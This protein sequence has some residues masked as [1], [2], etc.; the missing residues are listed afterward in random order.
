MNSAVFQTAV[1][2]FSGR[3]KDSDLIPKDQNLLFYCLVR[4]VLTTCLFICWISSKPLYGNIVLSI[5]NILHI[6]VYDQAFSFSCF[7]DLDFI[8]IN[9][10]MHKWSHCKTQPSERKY[11]RYISNYNNFQYFW[12]ERYKSNYN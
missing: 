6:K 12:R 5:C 1:E 4:V 7:F 8:T 11:L 9:R 10:T 3:I 2:N